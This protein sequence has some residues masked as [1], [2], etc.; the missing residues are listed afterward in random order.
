[1]NS[2]RALE[3]Q[4]Q[5]GKGD[6][7][8]LKRFRNSLLNI[9]A[10]LPP[11]ILGDIFAWCLV[12]EIDR[13]LDSP[14]HFDGLQK[15]SYNFLLV[16]HHWF[17]VASCTPELWSFWGSTLQ[18]WEK[19]HHRWAGTAPLDLVLDGGK[20]DPHV[21]FDGPLQDAVRIGVMRDTIRQVHLVSDDRTTLASII[22]S[23]VP[24]DK[25]AQNENIESIVWRKRGF[26]PLDISTFFARSH[27]SKLR[28]LQL[29]G[30]FRIS[31]WDRLA[32]RTTLL[33][34]LSL[35]IT[36]SLP[37]P[38]P[39][40]TTSQL[41]SI[42]SSNPN[43]RELRLENEAL[44]VDT[45][46]STLQVSL[47]HLRVLSVSGGFRRLFG[48]LRQLILPE[49][50]DDLSLTGYNP[51]A[52]GIS[53]NLGPYMWDYF[54]RGSW[55]QDRLEVSSC[56]T[57]L[58]IS[59]SVGVASR[60]TA[61]APRVEFALLLGDPPPPGGLEQ[62][63]VS[64]FMPIPREHIASFTA[65]LHMKL[66]EELAFAMPNIETLHLT[67]VD[68]YE[69]FLQPDPDGPHANTKLFPSLRSLCLEDVKVVDDGEWGHL[70][71]Y[72][73]HQ[74]SGGQIVSLEVIG[75]SPCMP[76]EVVNE[77]EGLVEWFAYRPSS[78]G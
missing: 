46:G 11:E 37:L 17:E 31:S 65:D 50:L 7:I 8:K 58:F 53:Q 22:S 20:C 49:T 55:F 30:N 61:S 64:L 76:P 56:C 33:T 18:E 47:C 24:D 26:F 59:I 32:S 40:P 67:D 29:S 48:L 34:T 43:L 66:P 60:P 10:R 2:I 14:S 69:G 38:V 25:S 72:L 28:F 5:E 27:L 70:I 6:V 52:E 54:R 16:C 13:S 41:L 74:T 9:S 1:M 45:D 42:L 63:F 19:H 73:A 71:T 44:P 36:E 35:E 62:L 78:V 51:T 77:V 12:R 57:R 23:L 21:P 39:T 3:M 75:D 4:I 15:G 68:L